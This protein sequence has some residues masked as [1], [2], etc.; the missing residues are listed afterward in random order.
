MNEGV[1]K[2]LFELF[3]FCGCGAPWEVVSYI[4][5]Y[6]TEIGKDWEERGNLK[7]DS[8]YWMAA[9]L[10]DAHGLTDHGTSVRAAWLTELGEEWL[11][12]LKNYEGEE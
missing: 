2:E 3:D 1:E 10:C 7:D 6:L 5:K 11:E 12:K 9:Y 4:K 8:A